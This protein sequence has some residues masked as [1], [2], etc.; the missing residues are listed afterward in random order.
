M[1]ILI[2]EDDKET[3][4][5]LTTSL[6]AEGFVVDTADDGDVGSRKIKINDYDLVIL[7]IALPGKDGRQICAEIRSVGKRRGVPIMMLSVKGEVDTKVDLLNM[8]ADDYMVKP[9]SYTELVARV[10]ALLRRPREMESD[11]LEINDLC[12]N[13][14]ERMVTRG[15]KEIHL[16]P[17]EFFLLEY[18]MRNRGRVLSRVVLLERV[19]DMNADLFTNTVETHIACLRRKLAGK[20]KRELISTISGTGYKIS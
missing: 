8:G 10:R 1:S 19:W 3:L 6:K 12:L 15:G 4:D 20:G 9:F 5:V 14:K 18:M 13:A 2:V 16:T 11:I 7:D 17:K